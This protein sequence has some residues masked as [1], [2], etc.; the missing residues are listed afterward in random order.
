MSD[1]GPE[2]ARRPHRPREPA[3]GPAGGPMVSLPQRNRCAPREVTQHVTRVARH[4]ALFASPASRVDGSASLRVARRVR[5]HGPGGSTVDLHRSHPDLCRLRD[6]LHALRCGPGVLRR[7]ELHLGSEALPQLPG[8]PAPGPRRRVGRPQ[9]RRPARLRAR[10]RPGRPRVLRGHLLAL[11]Q[12]RPGSVQAA[13]RQARLLLRLLPRGQGR[14]RRST[15]SPHD[16]ARPAAGL[17][18]RMAREREEAAD[19]TAE[20]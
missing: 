2:P 19:R 4:Q 12:Q 1:R 16:E 11:R 10:R 15:R 17:R 7:E 3:G 5:A 18:G 6:E 14:L 20:E 8:Q 9:H 13:P